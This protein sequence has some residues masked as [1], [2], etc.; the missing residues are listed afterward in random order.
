MDTSKIAH[1]VGQA[2]GQTQEKGSQLME[3]VGNA[4]QSTK[5]TVQ[6]MTP[7]AKENYQAGQAQGQAQEKGSQLMEKAGNTLQSTRETIQEMVPQAKEN[8]HA[9]QAQG[10]AQTGQQ[11]KAT[12]LKAA[13][14]AKSATGMNK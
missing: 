11:V 4:A 8:Y 3:K 14:A 7:Q 10:Q 9:G 12:T 2:Q 13:D 6:E 1:Q 5:E